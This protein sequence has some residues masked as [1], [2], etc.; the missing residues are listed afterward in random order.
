[1]D[2]STRTLTAPMPTRWAGRILS[3][4]AVAFLLMDGVI[5]VLTLPPAVEATVGLGYPAHLVLGIGVLELA[6]LA[7]YAL[8]RTAP[9]GAILLTGYL[10][11]ALAT[12]VRVGAPTFSLVFPLLLGALVWG[13]LLL[14]DERVRALFQPR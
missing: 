9:L 7:A 6:C 11:G 1:M 3:G 4:L 10:G 2:T 12:Q 8:P 14:R 5:K 13:G